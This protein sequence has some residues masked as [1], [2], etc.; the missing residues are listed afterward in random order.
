MF[1]GVS[2]MLDEQLLVA[3]R[4]NDNLLVRV[5]PARAAELLRKPGAEPATMG[6][7]RPMGPGWISV[8]G[9][10]VSSVEPLT[11]WLQVAL[12]HHRSRAGN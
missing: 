10:A 7:D 8:S 9:A 12:D 3:I 1:G 2:I 11:S 4:R 5:D 6:A